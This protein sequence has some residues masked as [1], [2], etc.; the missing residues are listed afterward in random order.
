MS[1]INYHEL[2]E[3]LEGLFVHIVLVLVFASPLICGAA[4]WLV[5]S[6]TGFWQMAFMVLVEAVFIGALYGAIFFAIVLAA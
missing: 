2:R 4:L 1:I 3:A 5:L 6:P